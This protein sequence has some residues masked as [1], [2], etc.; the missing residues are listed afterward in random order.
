MTIK[1]KVKLNFEELSPDFFAIIDRYQK[2]YK[3]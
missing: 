1:K 2:L 3:G